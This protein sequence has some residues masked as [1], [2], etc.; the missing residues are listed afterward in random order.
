MVAQNMSSPATKKWMAKQ[1]A[2][3]FIN[4]E[5]DEM[6][7]ARSVL[8]T[9]D[10]SMEPHQPVVEGIKVSYKHRGRAF[11]KPISM[12]SRAAGESL[13]SFLEYHLGPKGCPG[14]RVD[15]G[16]HAQAPMNMR[17]SNI[18]KAYRWS[19]NVQWDDEDRR[20]V[21]S[22]KAHGRFL[23]II[24]ADELAPW[25]DGDNRLKGTRWGVEQRDIVD[26]VGDAISKDWARMCR[27]S[28]E[29]GY[30][31]MSP[32]LW[33]RLYMLAT[34]SKQAERVVKAIEWVTYSGNRGPHFDAQEGDLIYAFMVYSLVGK[35]IQEKGRFQFAVWS[36]I[37]PTLD[38]FQGGARDWSRDTQT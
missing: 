38:E 25:I 22:N 20:E 33:V 3:T 11:G 31:T 29:K 23:V 12:E 2:L 35:S 1:L 18:D 30:L 37:D 15:P 5:D 32:G 10:A 8:A 34:K 9:S 6:S 14:R 21:A 36:N 4:E 24:E 19:K 27:H 7:T 13:K 16:W 28:P 26:R 17:A